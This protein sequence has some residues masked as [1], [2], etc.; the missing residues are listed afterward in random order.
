LLAAGR[1]LP[2]LGRRKALV[3]FIEVPGALFGLAFFR[4]LLANS[5]E[6]HHGF[7]HG[8]ALSV[9]G[10]RLKSRLSPFP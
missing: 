8:P 7:G 9:A 1:L 6:L 5:R 4:H 3:D 2:G 10:R